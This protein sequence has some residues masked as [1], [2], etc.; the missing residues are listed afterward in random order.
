MLSSVYQTACIF[1]TLS[2]SAAWYCS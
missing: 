2:I 1:R